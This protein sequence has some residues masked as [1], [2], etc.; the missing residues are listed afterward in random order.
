[1]KGGSDN[2]EGRL[3][4]EVPRKLGPRFRAGSASE[5]EPKATILINQICHRLQHHSTK[6]PPV[7]RMLL[8]T[9]SLDAMAC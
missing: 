7:P 3:K 6:S 1:M 8:R 9:Q 4:D 5:G 2:L